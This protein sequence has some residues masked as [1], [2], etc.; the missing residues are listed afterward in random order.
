MYPSI[1]VGPDFIGPDFIGPDFIG[2]DFIGPDFI[3]TDFIGP[4]FIRP[5][6]IGTNQSKKSN[7]K[8]GPDS[9]KPNEVT[10]IK[11]ANPVANLPK[12]VQSNA[13]LDLPV[14][15]C[16]PRRSGSSYKP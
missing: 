7:Q 3:G 4:D 10:Q 1:K 15:L 2:P 13:P 16:K 9:R 11:K 14:Q 12:E 5:D 8:V 6:F